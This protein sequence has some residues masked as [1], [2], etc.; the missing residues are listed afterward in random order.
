MAA[1]T[2]TE[3]VASAGPGGVGSPPCLEVMALVAVA[4]RRALADKAQDGRVTLA[5]V[6]G[7]L[8]E[9]S[10]P[11]GALARVLAAQADK[12]GQL[13]M[14]HPP[15]AGRKKAFHRLMV[16]PFE[17]LLD[18]EPP[19]FPRSCLPHYFKVVDAAGG[20]WL[21]KTEDVC[22]AVLQSLLVEHGRNLEWDAFYTDTRVRHVLA[23]ALRH[24]VTTLETPA[25]QW[26]WEQTMLRPDRNGQ[27]PAKEQADLVYRSLRDTWRALELE[28]HAPDPARGP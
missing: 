17:T 26:L 6:D 9:L 24:L 16:R 5:E 20:A 11:G 3:Q 2:T 8:A 4:L 21:T 23:Y 27:A 12:C 15:R 18:G 14:A 1:S 19:A 7:V 22:R 10:A 25:G 28:I 13:M